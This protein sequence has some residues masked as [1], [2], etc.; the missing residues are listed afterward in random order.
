MLGVDRPEFLWLLFLVVPTLLLGFY[1]RRKLGR[2]RMSLALLLRCLVLLIIVLALAGLT[3]RVPIDA[4]GVVF[5]VDRSASVGAGGYQQAIDFV[6]EALE[7]QEKDDRAGVVVFGA[8]PLVETEVKDKLEIHGFESD[9]SPH[10]TDIA[11]AIRLSTALLPSD[12]TRRIIVL[13]DGEQT[14][15][16]AATETLLTVAEDL[17]IGVVAVGDERGPE[18]LVE[19]ILMPARVNEGAAYE[20]RVVTRSHLPAV[21]T[22]RLYRNADYLGETKVQLAGGRADVFTFRQEA[23]TPGLYR[24]RAVLSV[25][26]HALDT[27]TENNEVVSTVQVSGR[28]RVLYVEGYPEH[29]QHL[30]QVLEG[31]GLEVDVIPMTDVPPGLP[32][33]RP[34]AA[35]IL[36]D[37][38]A[39]ALTRRQQEAIRLY[40]RDLG[41]GLV[42]VGGDRSFG[43]GGY[44]NTPVEAALPVDMDIKDKTR[45]PKLGMV[46]AMDKSGSMGGGAGSK[47]ALAKEAGIETAELLS[48][49]DMLGIIGFDSAS[50]WIVPLQ[51]LDNRQE[52]IDTIASIRPGG[53]TD[54][55][56]ALSAGITELKKTDAAL[57]H[58]ILIS[59]GMTTA[60]AYEPLIR[61]AHRTAKITVT[62]VAIGGDADRK[63]MEDFAKWGGGNYYLVTDPNS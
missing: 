11:S 29:R 60:G 52:V 6:S 46:L 28:P 2:I 53:G 12:R 10:Q 41:R 15:G 13:T 24:Y 3:R 56:P 31:E 23:K 40:V 17:S 63:T 20:V 5:A 8:E 49:R 21:G 18:V 62:A 14:R 4:L 33:L 16:D 54:I 22:L 59:D 27:L 38:P 45:F 55:Y 47:L 48:D 51:E 9:P 44:Y 34:Y 25:D 36:S 26:D 30:T 50:S 43:L 7:Y 19:D 42:M 58:V 35:I 37:V 32:E 57:K 61:G 39:Y 1:T